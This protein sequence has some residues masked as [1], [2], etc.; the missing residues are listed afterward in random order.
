MAD[1]GCVAIVREKNIRAWKQLWGLALIEGSNADWVDLILPHQ[2]QQRLQRH[3][4]KYK[5]GAQSTH[6][7]AIPSSQLIYAPAVGRHER[8]PPVHHNRLTPPILGMIMPNM[9]ITKKPAAAKTRRVSATQR[10]AV[11]KTPVARDA[12]AAYRVPGIDARTRT[13]VASFT[14]SAMADALFTTTQQRVL[15]RLFGLPDRSFFAN[16]LI[17]LTGSGSG[18]VQRELARLEAS[19]LV[20]ANWIGN[21]KHYQANK[22]CPIFGEIL[23]IVQKTVGV[24]GPLQVALQPLAAQIRAAFVYGSIA[25]NEDTASS[26][27]DVM[28]ISDSLGYADV[29]SAV[30]AATAQLGRP[31][32]PTLLTVAEVNKRVKAGAAFMTRVLAQPKI[33]LI[34]GERDLGV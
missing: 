11:K 23:G 2:L 7:L 30:E 21:Q 28:V 20:T 17:G 27:I 14:A 15:A 31:I 33:W 10:A 25:K 5:A 32:N 18:A 24:V 22:D 29:F 4:A 16:E 6:P 26:D 1:L 9:G 12:V 19:G 34:G 8:Q 3:F 13:P